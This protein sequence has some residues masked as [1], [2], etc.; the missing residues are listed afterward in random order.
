M[1]KGRMLL[2]GWPAEPPRAMKPKLKAALRKLATW[3]HQDLLPDHFVP[4]AD[5][6]YSYDRR[7]GASKERYAQRAAEGFFHGQR[8]LPLIHTG[9][10]KREVTRMG[11]V[12]GGS[13]TSATL[14]MLAPKYLNYPGRGG[15]HR[16]GYMHEELTQIARGEMTLMS[17][18]AADEVAVQMD[19]STA[20]KTIEV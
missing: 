1:I 4:G 13:S 5:A 16:W 14:R 10:L 8:H 6:K 15:H 17:R 11:W 19:A 9:N 12:A 3:W 20:R 2:T 18:R 7:V